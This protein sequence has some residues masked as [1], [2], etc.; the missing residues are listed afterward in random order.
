MCSP[1]YLDSVKVGSHVEMGLDMRGVMC[2]NRLM[3]RDAA[4]HSFLL[5][6]FYG[7]LGKSKE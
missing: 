7:S 5:V 4:R 1:L 3:W 2:F 6:S